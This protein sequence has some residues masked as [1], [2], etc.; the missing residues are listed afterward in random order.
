MAECI[1]RGSACYPSKYGLVTLV[2]SRGESHFKALTVSQ[3][4][5]FLDLQWEGVLGEVEKRC[6]DGR[7]MQHLGEKALSLSVV[8]DVS[9]C[10][11]LVVVS[12]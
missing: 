4:H 9:T 12:C 5:D 6:V 7:T 3:S 10:I 8:L 2:G 1:P 11:C